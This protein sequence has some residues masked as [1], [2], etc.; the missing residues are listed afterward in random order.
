M[1]IS[2][3]NLS[4]EAILGI[5]DF[6]RISPQRIE[7]ECEIDY[8]FIKEKK[9]FIDYAEIANL[10]ESTMKSEKFFLIEDA[11]E[12]LFPLLKDKYPQIETMKITICKPDIMPNCRV[13]VSDFR[14]F[15]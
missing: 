5:L 13:L 8:Q 11:I 9:N 1:T 10:I 15:L 3:Q 2:I 12:S 4:F 6:E 14:S 7:V